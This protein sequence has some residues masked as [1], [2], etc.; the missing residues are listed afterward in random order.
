MATPIAIVGKRTDRAVS[1]N[2]QG[3]LGSPVK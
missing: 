1:L 2:I 3:A